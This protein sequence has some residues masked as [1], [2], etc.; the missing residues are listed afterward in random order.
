MLRTS[1]GANGRRVE[2]ILTRFETAWL[3]RGEADLARYLPEPG[4]PDRRLVLLELIRADREYRAGAGQLRTLDDYALDFPEVRREDLRELSRVDGPESFGRG[5]HSSPGSFARL[6]FE[7]ED[8][9]PSDGPTEPPPK[10]GPGRQGAGLEGPARSYLARQ[11]GGKAGRVEKIEDWANR[12]RSSFNAETIDVFVDLHESDPDAASRLADAVVRLPV[13]GEVFQGFRLLGELGRGA[14][15]RV[16]LASQ[17]DLAD[18]PVA[19]KISAELMTESRTLAQLQ[20]TNIVPIFSSHRV[21][22]F[23][24]VCMPYFGSTTLKDIFEDL[25]DQPSMPTSGRG[26]VQTLESHREVDPASQGSKRDRPATG[27]T[28]E[29]AASRPLAIAS[30]SPSPSPSPGASSDPLSLL[31]RMSYVEAIL[32]IGSKL[33]DGLAHAHGRGILHRDLKPANILLTDSGQPMLLDFN[34]SEDTKQPASLASF[35]GTLPYMAPEHIRAFRGEGDGGDVDARSDIYALGIILYELLAGRHPFATRPGC[36]AAVLDRMIADRSTR[37]PGLRERNPQVSP[38]VE[39]IVGHCLEPDP[40]RRYRSA[41]D[42]RDDLERQMANLPLKHAPEPSTRERLAKWARRHPRLTSSTSVAVLIGAVALGIFGGLMAR[43]R[44]LSKYE[45]I[46]SL[47]RFRDDSSTARYLLQT[48]IFDRD[49]RARA[50]KLGGEALSRYGATDDPAWRSKRLV[51]S[52]EPDDRRALLEEAGALLLALAGAGKLDA[53]AIPPEDPARPLGLDAALRLCTRS[54]DCFEDDRRPRGLLER[55]ADLI[56][57]LGRPD[58]A[59]RIRAEAAKRP[60]RTALDFQLAASA[61]SHLGEYRQALPLAL[62]STRLDPRDFWAWFTLGLSHERLS[63][64]REAAACFG[65]CIAL[66][67]TSPLG[68]FDRGVVRTR[69]ADYDQARRDFDR[70]IALDPKWPDALVERAIARKEGG[71]PALAVIDYTRAIEL[72]AT[73][74]RIYFLRSAA[75]ALAGDAEGARLDRV[76]GFRRE[77]RDA[78]G[79]VVRAMARTPK[80]T[81]AALADL[82]QALKINPRSLDALQDRAYILA[83][84]LDRIA[85]A[86]VVYDQLVGLYPDFVLARSSRGVLRAILGRREAAHLDAREALWRDTSPR[87]LFQVAG[88]Y[89]VT[90]KAVPE[91]RVEA[92][93]LLSTALRGGFGFDELAH[94]RELDAIRDQPEFR[95]LLD[96]AKAIGKDPAG[97]Q[98]PPG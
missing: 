6:R 11:A 66:R 43:A 39:S 31:G 12:T 65:T 19:L 47:A 3:V 28:P 29:P 54:A 87:T 72:G 81:A 2:E 50:V 62:E 75:R 4:H 71:Q 95:Q 49:R 61:H 25:E 59:A 55:Q 1:I 22:P 17:G 40:A 97:P 7:P 24:A 9:D 23:H 37:P 68:W 46:A 74:T 48:R 88:I 15:G 58:E 32:W 16:Y 67:P 45:A 36:S 60:L 73:E 64:E 92:F 70:A 83:E 78:L 86:E 85:E 33:A 34:L 84:Q 14:F 44:E 38:A 57:L 63:Q 79:W 80:E 76:E 42:L 82:D 56:G 77:P 53:E 51:A 94:D 52:L 69:Q 26:L 90:S 5:P 41:A 21:E 30:P 98:V 96:A 35:G 91:D 27:E 20:H 10:P 93:R 89:A 8:W 13:P 18:R